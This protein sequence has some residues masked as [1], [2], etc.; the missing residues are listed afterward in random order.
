MALTTQANSSLT[1]FLIACTGL[2]CQKA[3]KQEKK[4]SNRVY[5]DTIIPL[6]LESTNSVECLYKHPAVIM[7]V[8]VVAQGT[9]K[10]RG[11]RLRLGQNDSPADPTATCLLCSHPYYEHSQASPRQEFVQ[12]ST[13][14][15]FSG[16]PSSTSP[17]PLTVPHSMQG[18]LQPPASPLASVSTNS[19]LLLAPASLPAATSTG[20]LTPSFLPWSPPGPPVPGTAN[21]RRLSP[22]G[23]GVSQSP[24]LVIPTL[25]RRPGQSKANHRET[26][27]YLVVIHP[28]PMHGTVSTEYEHLFR[29]IRAPIPQKIGSFITQARNFGLVFQI[30]DSIQKDDP[31]GPSFHQYLCAHFETAGLA[32]SGSSSPS[33]ST[34]QKPTDAQFPW[35]FL[36]TGKGQWS[37]HGA[38]LLPA[39]V[40]PE[41][42]THREIQRNGI[43]LPVPPGPYHDHKLVFILPLWDIIAGPINGHGIHCCL[44]PRIWNGH[45]EPSLHEQLEEIS[46]TAICENGDP[47]AIDTDVASADQT[48]GQLTLLEA[49]TAGQMSS[50]TASLSQSSLPSSPSS[51]AA[52]PLSSTSLATSPSVS[53]STPHRSPHA[54]LRAW[55]NRLE[56]DIQSRRATVGHEIRDIEITASN[57]LRAAQGF[58]AICKAL[59][60]ESGSADSE[61]PDLPEDVKITNCM[62]MNIVIGSITANIGHGVGN[63]PMRTFW[64]ALI[65]LITEYSGHWQLVSDGY[66]VPTVTSLPPSDDDLASFH[67]YSL[68][69]RTGFIFG[70]ELLPISPHSLVYLLDGYHTCT[71]QSF[72]EATSPITSQRLHSWPPPTVI[73]PSTGRRELDISAARDPYTM[74][75][76]VDGTIQISQLHCLSEPAQMV[77]SQR[78][79]C[80]MVFGNEAPLT[81]GLHPVYAALGSA[82]QHVIHDDMKFSDCSHRAGSHRHRLVDQALKDHDP[83]ADGG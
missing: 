70:M 8:S 42:V 60:Q 10:F 31:A 45:F 24:L 80:H 81:H 79:V 9:L 78:L 3:G 32:F 21:D 48:A 59:C 57:A 13:P 49:L 28:E 65:T 39:R 19:G 15:L 67:A 83:E 26:T 76:E 37:A 4:S 17:G 18:Y 82:F 11:I 50:T 44:A 38:K 33:S 53:V 61:Q 1:L 2:P 25:R 29:D 71:A 6:I 58:L 46:C 56:H 64:G 5:R 40:T 77:L 66:Y 16:R 30:E 43:R 22:H 35:S 62:P 20:W 27:K 41:H 54:E 75:L 14:S 47:P 73:N 51:A 12:P 55:R 74:I 72:L 36:M 7:R 68:I 63:G 23:L 34:S 69:I 52:S